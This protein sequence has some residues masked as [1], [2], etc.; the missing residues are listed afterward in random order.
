[1]SRSFRSGART[2]RVLLPGKPSSLSN[3]ALTRRVRGL[4]NQEGQRTQLVENLY[5]NVT[6]AAN[7]AD[8]NYL[9][10]LNALT[11]DK[12]HRLRLFIYIQAAAD[13]MSR[14]ILFEDTQPEQ[15]EAIAGD[16]LLVGTDPFSGY[17]SAQNK[18]HPF[19]ATRMTKNVED[20][21][22]RIRII[23]DLM[24]AHVQGG[25]GEKFT[26]ILDIP[27]RGRKKTSNSFDIGILV[28]SDAANEWDIMYNVDH[29]DLDI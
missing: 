21:P 16:I 6:V 17:E 3:K 1:M 19:G 2:T 18:V 12:L 28:M 11:N 27:F 4:S 22:R 24:I 8:I 15:T 29:T 26:R 20:N 10:N 7:V 14:F 13:S 5:N 25:P 9:T 23:K